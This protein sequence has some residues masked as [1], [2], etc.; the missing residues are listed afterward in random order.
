[1]TWHAI[2][3]VC[4]YA[5]FA[6]AVASSPPF[7]MNPG[8]HGP[9][10]LDRRISLFLCLPLATLDTLALQKEIDNIGKQ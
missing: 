7:G 2:G 3:L 10:V 6:L 4:G 9:R 8:V 5:A 1:L